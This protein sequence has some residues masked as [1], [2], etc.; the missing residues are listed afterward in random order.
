M[1]VLVHSLKTIAVLLEVLW[2]IPLIQTL[3]FCVAN[4]FICSYVLG[5]K[6]K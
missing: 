4:G 5:E 3:V 2:V 6:P 1:P